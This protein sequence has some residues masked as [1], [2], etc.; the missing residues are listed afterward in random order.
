M[1]EQ[2]TG[3]T[4]GDEQPL[5]SEEAEIIQWSFSATQFVV[6]TAYFAVVCRG[7][8]IWALDTHKHQ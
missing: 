5:L 2:H 3:C 4:M 7:S 1:E 6:I 8:F